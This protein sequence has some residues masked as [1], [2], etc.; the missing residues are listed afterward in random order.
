MLTISGGGGNDVLSA[1]GA[2]IGDVRMRLNGDV[3]ND[4]IT[5][6]SGQDTLDGG[7]GDDSLAGGLGNDTLSGQLGND[8]L[9]GLGGISGSGH[10]W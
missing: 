1:V 9:L 8:S 5:G 6:S 7:D 4:S 10:S 3:G 2:A